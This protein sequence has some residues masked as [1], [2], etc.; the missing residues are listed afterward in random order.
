MKKLT[1]IK[2]KV[3]DAIAP[4]RRFLPR[5][6]TG[7]GLLAVTVF[8]LWAAAFKLDVLVRGPGVIRVESHNIMVQ[9]PDGGQIEKLLVREGQTVHKGQLLAV[10]DNTYVSEEFAKNTA[11]L[12]AL[13]LREQRLMAE[14]GRTP[15]APQVLRIRNKQRPSQAN[16]HFMSRVS[17]RWSKPRQSLPCRR[18][19]ARRNWPSCAAASAIWK[20]KLP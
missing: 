2:S 13:R 6:V 7:A 16:R 12:D 19:S 14:I 3:A 11:A 10:M 18:T 5:G 15:F 8:A 20:R 4:Y 1:V 9:H 17:A